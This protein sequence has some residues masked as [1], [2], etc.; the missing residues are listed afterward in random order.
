MEK[1]DMVTPD[2][3]FER[4]GFQYCSTIHNFFEF[5]E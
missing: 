5:V 2:S 3:I 1:T 4:Y